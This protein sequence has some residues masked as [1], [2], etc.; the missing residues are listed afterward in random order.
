VFY[1]L[2]IPL[3]ILSAPVLVI[4]LIIWIV[5]EFIRIGREP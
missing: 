4:W 3:A 1:L 2:L 5:R